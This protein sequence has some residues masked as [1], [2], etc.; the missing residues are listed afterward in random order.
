MRNKFIRAKK[1]NFC[2]NLET[3]SPC[4]WIAE[5]VEKINKN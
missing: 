3:Y 2:L 4:K 1:A 5:I